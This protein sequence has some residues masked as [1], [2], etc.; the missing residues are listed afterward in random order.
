MKKLLA[1]LLA[2][3]VVGAAFAADAPAVTTAISV[4]GENGIYN[5]GTNTAFDSNNGIDLDF[6]AASDKFGVSMEF[7]YIE[8]GTVA[9]GNMYFN[10]AYGWYQPLS[11]VKVDFGYLYITSYRLRN[12]MLETMM[13]GAMGENGLAV[14]FFP[15]EGLSIAAFLPTSA[16]KG[17]V[18]GAAT[19]DDLV[20]DG[21]KEMD[22]FAKYSLADIGTFYAS[23][24]MA[25]LNSKI[26]GGADLKMVPNAK[27]QLGAE[28]AGIGA[29]AQT[30][31]IYLV[32]GYTMDA[33]TLTE[34]VDLRTGS[35]AGTVF[36]WLSNT[37]IAYRMGDVR[38]QLVAKVNNAR[39]ATDY[40]KY[41]ITPSIRLYEGSNYYNIGFNFAGNTDEAQGGKA[42]WKLPL[43]YSIAF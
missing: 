16:E 35:A 40:I 13:G 29:A 11:M 33:L 36:G 9:P 15:I 19:Y 8:D 10:Y 7:E 6:D 22:F 5:N 4:W 25:N 26:N 17:F 41:S 43:S 14:E 42:T 23:Y 24:Q 28:Y 12:S 34:E 30:T 3:V 18:S 2:L 38:Y 39:V 1:I 20:A 27:I 31:T 37:T 32:G 21:V